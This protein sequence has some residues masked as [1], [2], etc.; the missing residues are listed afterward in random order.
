[1]LVE[2]EHVSAQVN[3]RILAGLGW[4]LELSEFAHHFVGRSEDHFRGEIEQHLGRRLDFDWSERYGHLHQEAYERELTTVPGIEEVV[5]GLA[6]PYCVASNSPHAHVR[7]VLEMTGLLP[8]FQGR[9]FSAEDVGVGEPAPDLFLHA[10]RSLGHPPQHCIVVEDSKVGVDAAL[11][12]RMPV[13]GY[14]G[15][16]TAP[17]L[18]A[19]ATWTVPH[20]RELPRLFGERAR[21]LADS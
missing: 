6:L 3:Q 18:L 21:A 7:S 1:V 16:L 20:M 9:I 12:A 17:G 10:A 2:T 8:Y 11:A 13:A 4:H 5:R 19:H 14:T 15:G